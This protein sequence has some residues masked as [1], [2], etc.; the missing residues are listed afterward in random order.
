[1]VGPLS[2][3]EIED[4][5]SSVR[6]LVSNEQRPR[7]LSRDLNAERLLLTPALRVVAET[8]PL[9]PL[10][11]DAPVVEAAEEAVA[12]AG[13]EAEGAMQVQAAVPPQGLPEA[14]ALAAPAAAQEAPPVQAP[15]FAPEPDAGVSDLSGGVGDAG[16]LDVSVA[17]EAEWEDEI[18]AEPGSVSLGEAALAADE[19]ELLPSAPGPDHP[20]ETA[21]GV[22]APG[23]TGDDAVPAARE[24]DGSAWVEDEPITFI[25]LRRR[26][27]SLSEADAPAEKVA[28]SGTAALPSA[29]EY[30]DE[31]GTP[32]AVLDEAAL[33]EIVRQTLRT[34]L[35]GELGE[36]ITRNVRKLVRA[37]INRALMA[38]DL[39]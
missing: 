24:R 28:A 16:S 6:R 22:T 2:S 17:A 14:D 35:Q 25:P 12:E 34:E 26:A 8:S 4:V 36:R 27:G 37:E 20:G 9:A 30:L 10:V 31:D 15:V 1:M 29:P 38:R 7:T 39:D 18:W 3:E 32:L 19:A 23:V 11:L 5:V 33:Q 13:A 21:P